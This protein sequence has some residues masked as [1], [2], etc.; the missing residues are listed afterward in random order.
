VIVG[1]GFG[2]LFSARALRRAQ[3]GDRLP[4]TWAPQETITEQHA[5]ARVLAIQHASAGG[6]PADDAPVTNARAADT[7]KTARKLC[8]I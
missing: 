8:P 4:R 2:G 3:L 5:I 1:A 6:E 7:S